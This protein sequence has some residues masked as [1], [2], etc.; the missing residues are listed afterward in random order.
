MNIDDRIIQIEW[1]IY[2]LKLFINGNYIPNIHIDITALHEERR[3]LK[4]EKNVLMK[5]LERKNKLIKIDK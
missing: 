2:N 3:N 1:E 5:K 4:K